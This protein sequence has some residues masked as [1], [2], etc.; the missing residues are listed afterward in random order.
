[1]NETLCHFFCCP[2]P[3]F[4]SSLSLGKDPCLPE[5]QRLQTLHTPLSS[6]SIGTIESR[7]SSLHLVSKLVSRPL[8]GR[9]RRIVTKLPRLPARCFF[10]REELDSWNSVEQDGRILFRCRKLARRKSRRRRRSSTRKSPRFT[11]KIR[12][13]NEISPDFPLFL[14]P[15]LLEKILK[16][17]YEAS[18]SL[19]AVIRCNF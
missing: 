4:I 3:G 1:M 2:P 16:R 15:F 12:R 7:S 5:P 17:G 19:L 10:L 6:S 13:G 8:Q 9:P 11:W 14:V 18:R